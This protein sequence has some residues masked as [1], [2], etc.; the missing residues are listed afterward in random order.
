MGELPAEKRDRAKRYRN[1]AQMVSDRGVVE[2]L[3][4]AAE[5]LERDADKNAAENGYF[6]EGQNID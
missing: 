2:H 1:I 3:I 5:E 6:E 4:A